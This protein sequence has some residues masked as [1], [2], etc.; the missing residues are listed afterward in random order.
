LLQT[1]I[2]TDRTIRLILQDIN[3]VV[4][5]A[6]LNQKTG[7]R[8]ERRLQN[9]VNKVDKLEEKFETYLSYVE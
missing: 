3:E 6:G 8:S 7:E 5:N 2:G 1:Q 9:L 4:A